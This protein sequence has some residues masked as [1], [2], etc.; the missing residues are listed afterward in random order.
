LEPSDATGK[1]AEINRLLVETFD[2]QLLRAESGRPLT[3]EEKS[4]LAGEV[5]KQID[6]ILKN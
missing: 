1:Y 2:T 4:H 6:R 5:K 3:D